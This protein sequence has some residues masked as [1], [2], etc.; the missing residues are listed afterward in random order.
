MLPS[1]TSVVTYRE[2]IHT[3]LL[4]APR[5]KVWRAWTD[6]VHVA[7]WWGPDGFTNTVSSMD[8]RTGGTWQFIMHG[9]DGTDYPNFIKFDEIVKHKRITYAHQEKEENN[10]GDPHCFN[11]E[12]IFEDL[13][14][15][16]KVTLHSFFPTVEACEAVKKFGAVEGGQQT[17]GKMAEYVQSM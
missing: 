16:T 13:G 17:L 15:K 2:I 7:R 14:D 3:R 9:P 1:D 8:V 4:D 6:P 12:V 11:A 5:A 10:A